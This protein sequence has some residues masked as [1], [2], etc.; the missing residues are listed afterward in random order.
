[1]LNRL[2]EPG[3]VTKGWLMGKVDNKANQ[4]VSKLKN[5]TNSMLNLDVQLSHYVT[6]APVN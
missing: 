3:T 6:S 4:D 1:M 5:K 2:E